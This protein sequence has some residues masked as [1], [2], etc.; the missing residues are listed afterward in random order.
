MYIYILALRCQIK[1]WPIAARR[2]SISMVTESEEIGGQ[3]PL[4]GSRDQQC[5]AA[6]RRSHLINFW[7]AQGSNVGEE[8]IKEMASG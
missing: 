1:L 6:L 7:V 2:K 5:L 3:Q 4:G 8:D